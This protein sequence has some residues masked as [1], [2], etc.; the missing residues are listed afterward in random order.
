MAA[1]ET[2]RW[3]AYPRHR[4]VS[5]TSHRKPRGR[6]TGLAVA[7]RFCCVITQFTTHLARAGT[8]PSVTPRDT[9]GVTPRTGL[10]PS[11]A[12]CG[13]AAG[14]DGDLPGAVRA[15]CSRR[16]ARLHL[17]FG[18]NAKTPPDLEPARAGSLLTSRSGHETTSAPTR[19]K[20]TCSAVGCR[21]MT[22]IPA[23]R[24]I[25]TAHRGA[26]PSAHTAA[27]AHGEQPLRHPVAPHNGAA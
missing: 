9:S 21:S 17:D 7:G 3:I 11:R 16:R 22:H 18:P 23:D 27:S 2:P 25:C 13:S 12:R 15:G 19:R 6:P 24:C 14:R 26:A 1:H 10:G 20:V 5:T 4:R 8:L